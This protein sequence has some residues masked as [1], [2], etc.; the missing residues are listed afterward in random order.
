MGHG[1][2]GTVFH[3]NQK[4]LCEMHRSIHNLSVGEQKVLSDVPLYFMSPIES[5]MERDIV[6]IIGRVEKIY[7]LKYVRVRIVLHIFDTENFNSI[8]FISSS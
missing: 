5:L 1:L 4:Q 7:V 3:L 8:Q 2:Y 6:S